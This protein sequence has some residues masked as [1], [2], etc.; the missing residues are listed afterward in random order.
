MGHASKPLIG[1]LVATVA[2]FALWVVALKHTTGSGSSG[3][4]SQGLG[5]YQSAINKAHQAVALSNTTSAAHG[6]AVPTSTPAR[7]RPGTPARPASTGVTFDGAP[8]KPAS[9]PSAS[10]THV[11]GAQQINLVQAAVDAHKVVALLFFNS[12]AADDQADKQELAAVPTEGGRVFKLAVPLSELAQYTFVTTQVPI[13]Q[14]PS[15]VII[16]PAQQAT[17]IT[18]YADS[19]EI[20]QL[21]N[22]ALK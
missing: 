18:G 3:S 11:S 14:S 2:F 20:A 1:L 12:A 16:N 4:Q 15:L 10:A 19:F 17:V 22:D 9:H 13:T 21:V 5:A 8:V 7:S 6:G